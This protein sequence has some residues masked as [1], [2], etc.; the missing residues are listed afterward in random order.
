MTKET[1]NEYLQEVNE[2]VWA[3]SPTMQAYAK[4]CCSDV[5]KSQSGYF[6]EFEKRDIKKRFCFGHG[7]NG[8]STEEETNNAFDKAQNAKTNEQYFIDE[9][10]KYYND[11]LKE[12][13]ENEEFYLVPSYKNTKICSIVT[14]RYFFYYPYEETK[15]IEKLSKQDLKNL[16]EVIESEKAKFQKRLNTYLKRYGLSN[17]HSWTYL[18]D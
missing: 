10:L 18:V 6:V 16:R 2:K 13:D 15:K 17:V 1:I 12:L 14:Q 11:W 5:F 4:K 7:Q 8:I 3:K 9:N